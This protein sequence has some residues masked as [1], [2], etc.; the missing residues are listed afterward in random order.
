MSIGATGPQQKDM[1]AQI[2]AQQSDPS[3]GVAKKFTT[4][5]PL[6]DAAKPSPNGG[7]N[8]PPRFGKNNGENVDEKG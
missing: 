8:N 4:A 3:F 6:E 5:A 1:L 7:T 2:F